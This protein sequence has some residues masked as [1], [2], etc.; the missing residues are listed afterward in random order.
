M[1]WSKQQVLAFIGESTRVG[2]LA[3]VSADGDPHVVPIWFKLDGDRVLIHTSGES[4]K[5]K[6]VRA[7]G[8]YSLVVDVD[9]MPYKGVSVSGQAEAV[10]EDAIDWRSLINELA[11][12]YM[13]PEAGPGFGGYIASMPGEHVTL[14]LSIDETESWDYST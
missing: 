14:V 2:R 1:S 13:G 6:N 3:T 9:T 4:K 10:G 8:K 7:T 5:A 11:V 12:T